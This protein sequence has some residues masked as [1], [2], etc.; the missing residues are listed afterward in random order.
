VDCTGRPAANSS[1]I[2][3]ALTGVHVVHELPVDHHHRGVVAGGVAF[4]ALE[5]EHAVGGGLPLADAELLADLIEQA[6]PPITAHSAVVHTP[7]WCLPPG[8]RLVHRVER[9][10]ARHL[11]GRDAQH[12]GAGL[13]AARGEI[14]PSTDCTR[15]SIGSSAE[16]GCG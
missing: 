14:R 3:A 5:G 13:D 8:L 15:C 6:S 1:I 2:V 16:R 7:T 9:G 4:D 10:H 12:L 11:R